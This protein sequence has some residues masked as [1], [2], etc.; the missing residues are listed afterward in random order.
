ME[1]VSNTRWRAVPT[2]GDIV[3]CHFPDDIN[4]RPKPR[5]ALIL[6][7]FDDAAPQLDVPVAYG[8]SER[9]TTLHRGEFTVLERSP[10]AVACFDTANPLYVQHGLRGERA[11]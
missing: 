9:T 10:A 4:P 7:V 8:T 5:P 3:S 11:I 2:A 1:S 6:A